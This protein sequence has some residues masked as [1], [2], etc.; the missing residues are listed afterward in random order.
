M[1]KEYGR[2]VIYA[3]HGV[4]SRQHLRHWMA[5]QLAN[6]L[7]EPIWPRQ[8]ENARIAAMKYPPAIRTTIGGEA[9]VGSPTHGANIVELFFGG[10]A[11]LRN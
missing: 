2:V 1:F 7:H 5:W 11:Y 6:R 3:T 9:I 8:F 4:T 10:S